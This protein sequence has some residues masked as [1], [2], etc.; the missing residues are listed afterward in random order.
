MGNMIPEPDS[1][2]GPLTGAANTSPSSLMGQGNLKQACEEVHHFPGNQ[3]F[4]GLSVVVV[5][6][7]DD[8]LIPSRGNDHP[9]LDNLK[10]RRQGLCLFL[11]WVDHVVGPDPGPLCLLMLP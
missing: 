3:L 1:Y 8:P 11:I 4:V 7:H 10:V 5:E 2:W 9:S 6:S